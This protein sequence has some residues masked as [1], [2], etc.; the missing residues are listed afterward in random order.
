MA[1]ASSDDAAE[2]DVGVRRAAAGL[3]VLLQADEETGQP[4]LTVA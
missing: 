3:E 1:A 2:I 4:M